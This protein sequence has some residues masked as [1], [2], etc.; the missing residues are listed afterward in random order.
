MKTLHSDANGRSGH[1]CKYSVFRDAVDSVHFSAE[2]IPNS[3]SRLFDRGVGKLKI[4]VLARRSGSFP[5]AG[6]LL[7]LSYLLIFLNDSHNCDIL[8]GTELDKMRHS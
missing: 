7:H 4:L 3:G 2:R 5:I 1:G 6:A 8:Y